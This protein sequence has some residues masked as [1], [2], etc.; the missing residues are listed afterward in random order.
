VPTKEREIL[1][2]GRPSLDERD[3]GFAEAVG[4]AV[5]ALR[6]RASV[7][8]FN[9]ALWRPPLD[10]ADDPMPPIA[11]IVDRGDP[12]LRPSDIG[13]MELFG[14]PIVGSDP[15]ELIDTLRGGL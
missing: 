11:R 1:V 5:V 7:R 10:A 14:T 2:V 12:G 15:Y 3:P 8:S 6:D 9:L 13:A 4:R